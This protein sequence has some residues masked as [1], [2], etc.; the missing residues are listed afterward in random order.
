MNMEV[1]TNQ[2]MSVIKGG[3]WIYVDGEWIWIDNGR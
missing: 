2:E 3:D 1:L